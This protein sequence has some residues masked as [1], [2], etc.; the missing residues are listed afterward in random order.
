MEYQSTTAA[1]NKLSA[2]L[3]AQPSEM[4][5]QPGHEQLQ[6]VGHRS[7]GGVHVYQVYDQ[8]KVPLKELKNQHNSIMRGIGDAMNQHLS[9]W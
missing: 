8:G 6:P 5:W 9:D 1:A 7:V 4:A 2:N 3:G